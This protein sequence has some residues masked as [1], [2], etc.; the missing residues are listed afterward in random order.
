[1]YSWP[2]N[3]TGLNCVGSFNKWTENNPYK[4]AN[5][6]F[7]HYYLTNMHITNIEI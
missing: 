3:N 5:V 4:S 2:L 7:M 6:Y 1:M